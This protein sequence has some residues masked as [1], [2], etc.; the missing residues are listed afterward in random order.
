MLAAGAIILLLVVLTAIVRGSA[1]WREVQPIV[2]FH[3]GTILLALALT[4]V[5]LLK[6]RGTG[7]HRQLGWAW[8]LAMFSTAAGSFFIRKT[9]G[10]GWSPIHV[11]S[12]LTVV[13]VPWLVMRARRHD[14]PGHRRGVRG[15]VTGALLIAGFFTLPFGRMLGRWLLG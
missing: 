15:T 6:A 9:T 5:L 13:L 2:W 8:S 10:S 3:L 11:L 7:Q 1:H 12:G 14:V 4:P